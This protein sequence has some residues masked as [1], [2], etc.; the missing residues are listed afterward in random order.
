[1][2]IQ[3]TPLNIMKGDLKRALLEINTQAI[4]YLSY[5]INRAISTL[6]I[7]LSWAF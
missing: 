1:M 5:E 7:H 2:C 6:A 3:K 4:Y